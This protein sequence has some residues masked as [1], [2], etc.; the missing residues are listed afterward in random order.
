M[1]TNYFVKCTNSG[2]KNAQQHATHRQI[3]FDCGLMFHHV[4]SK[5]EAVEL[6]K[7][8]TLVSTSIYVRIFMN[9]ISIIIFFL[10]LP[11]VFLAVSFGKQNRRAPICTG[12][13]G[14]QCSVLTEKW[15]GFVLSIHGVYYFMHLSNYFTFTVFGENN[16]CQTIESCSFSTDFFSFGSDNI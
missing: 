4:G 11:Q 15:S 13:L 12:I 8:V 1:E 9:T 14:K 2:A 6:I 5:N 16:D 10:I 3:Q 7:C